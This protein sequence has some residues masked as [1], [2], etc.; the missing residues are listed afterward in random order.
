MSPSLP[1]SGCLALPLPL[2]RRAG[3]SVV[4]L[5]EPGWEGRGSD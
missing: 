2:S 5:L 3:K 4:C 1:E